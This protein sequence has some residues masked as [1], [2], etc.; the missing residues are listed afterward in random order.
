MV[1]ENKV[2]IVTGGAS[3]IGEE[4]CLRFAEQGARVAIADVN[5][6]GANQVIKKIEA[7]GGTA[8]H[9]HVDIRDHQKVHESV[10]NVLSVF[11]TVDVLVNC[12]GFNQFVGLDQVTPE[13]WERI[14]SINLEGSWNFCSAVVGPMMQKRAGKIINVGSAAAILAIPKALPYVVAK[15]AVVG[16]TRALAVDLGPY[17][18]NVNCICPGPV[19][20]P[21]LS[22]SATT[23][24][25]REIVKTIPLARL[26]KPSDL[27]HA[28]VFLASS[29]SDWITGVVLPVDGGLVSCVRA[30]H[31]E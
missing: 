29:L 11:G 28:A 15:H 16:L 21:L 18:I 26:G 12:A 14:R 17:N 31:W 30:H 3:G 27:A 25:Q 19:Q 7:S 8:L 9:L 13:L 4:I 2:A 22:Q 10:A 20:T 1:L 24:F 23:V 5:S 6:E